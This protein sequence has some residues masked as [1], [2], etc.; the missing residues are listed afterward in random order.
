MTHQPHLESADNTYLRAFTAKVVARNDQGLVLDTTLFYPTGGGQLFDT[1]SLEWAGGTA[2]VTDVRK[3]SGII[4]TID[5]EIPTGTEV[6][7]TLDWER[8]YAHMRNH[9][10][11]HIVSALAFDLHNAWTTGNQVKAQGS[12]LDLG[13]IKKQDLDLADFQAKVNAALGSGTEVKISQVARER[14]KEIV[15]EGRCDWDR[16]PQSITELRLVDIPGYDLTPCAG[17]HVRNLAE[18]GRVTRIKL[19]NKGKDRLRMTYTLEP[20][21]PAS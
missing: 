5:A 15:P 19:D 18:I 9:T 10:A 21:T 6:H 7:A 11:Q 12:R 17:T 3:S 4:H 2:R 1:G 8:R 14:A 20:P 13:G 16:L